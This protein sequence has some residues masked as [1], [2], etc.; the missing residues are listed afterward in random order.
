VR[1]GPLRGRPPGVARLDYQGERA[2]IRLAPER[3]RQLSLKPGETITLNLQAR[4]LSGDTRFGIAF[5]YRKRGA[6]TGFGPD[7]DT[8]YQ[9]IGLHTLEAYGPDISCKQIGAQWREHLPD[10]SVALAEGLALER[11]RT[12]ILPP[13]SGE[14]PI[15]EAIGGQMKGEIWG[16]VC[17]G[18]PDLAA[19]YAR[20]DGVVAH[21][22]NGVYGEQFIAVMISSA[23]HERD[24]RRLIDLGLS[25]IPRD[26]KYAAVVREVIAWHDRYPDW[27][28]TRRVLLAQHPDICN[29]VYGEAGIV[30]LALL[31]GG[32]DFERSICI[33][34]SCGNDTD[35]NTASVGALI[36]CIIGAH[37]IPKKWKDPVDDDFRCFARGLEQW[38]I[39]D[40]ARRICAAGRQVLAYHGSGQRFT[41]R[42]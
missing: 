6:R 10:I 1:L 8:T 36:G 34:A 9:I 33:A 4:W 23:F 11:M 19:E 37:A 22:G 24:V 21:C 27:R 32:G 12:G 13:A 31:Y 39:S 20:R 17:P 18:C 5:D 3:A 25:R 7:D 41:S 2:W 30:V 26:S 40:L 15:G 38:R 29:P 16:L 35:C 42:L 28:D 14:H